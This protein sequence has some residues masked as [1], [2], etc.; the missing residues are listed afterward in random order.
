M[1]GY[2]FHDTNAPNLG[3]MLKN[4]LF[5][6]SE[7]CMV[8]HL[9]HYCEKDSVGKWMGKST[10]FYLFI[11]SKVYSCRCTW[12]AENWPEE[13]KNLDLMRKKLMKHLDLGAPTSIL[14]LRY[15]RKSNILSKKV[16]CVRNKLQSLTVQLNLMLFIS[17]D[18]G[19]RMDGI[20]R[21]RSLGSG[22]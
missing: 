7:T 17:L 10:E 9:P 11:E 22:C 2:V 19:L 1:F 20:P 13:N 8:T 21:S 12:M 15:H 6:L 14:Y 3:P 4:P 18:V 5:F 16:G